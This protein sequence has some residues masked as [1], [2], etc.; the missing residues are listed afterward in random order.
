LTSYCG[1]IQATG[2]GHGICDSCSPGA[3]GGGGGGG[4]GGSQGP[5]Q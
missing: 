3:G 2:S 4:G 1:F 5:P